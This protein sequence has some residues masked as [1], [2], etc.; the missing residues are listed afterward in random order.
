MDGVFLVGTDPRSKRKTLHVATTRRRVSSSD[1]FRDADPEILEGTDAGADAS[2]GI[3][4]DS[5]AV[6]KKLQAV[7]GN[8]GVEFSD[9][10]ECVK[11]VVGRMNRGE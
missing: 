1:I 11:N 3:D 8:D 10:V 9:G 7:E 4:S 2:I 6:P 5:Q